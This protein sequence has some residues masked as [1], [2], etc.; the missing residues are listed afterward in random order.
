MSNVK[1]SIKKISFV[2]L[3]IFTS[4]SIY[5]YFAI[6]N[7]VTEVEASASY[8]GFDDVNSLTE[9]AELVALVTPTKDFLDR[10]HVIKTY[11]TGAIEDFY[12]LTDI[13]VSKVFKGDKAIS[14][15]L[16]IVEPIS[17]LQ[18][19]EGK[20]KINMEGYTEM[21]KGKEYV[22]FLRKNYMGNYAI[23]NMAEG[24]FEIEEIKSLTSSV[25]DS[26]YSVV[27][28]V[29]PSV[30]S[31]NENSQALQSPREQLASQIKQK[32]FYE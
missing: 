27:D 23:I 16:E 3:A 12:T 29:Y 10:E 32:F 18:T 28:D 11:E 31:K 26:V 17:L 8:L 20:Y 6:F 24:K 21:E 14:R 13:N 4:L 2:L 9:D 30:L 1:N 15:N 19:L 22:V 7:S 5:Y 25:T